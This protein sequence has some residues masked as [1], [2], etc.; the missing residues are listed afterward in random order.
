MFQAVARYEATIEVQQRAYGLGGADVAFA[1]Y[2]EWNGGNSTM[3]RLDAATF[4]AFSAIL[5]TGRAEYDPEANQLRV[6]G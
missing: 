2:F 1:I 4:A 3:N 6:A 5:A